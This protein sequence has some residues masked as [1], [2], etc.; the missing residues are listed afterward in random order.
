[1]KDTEDAGRP[2][3]HSSAELKGIHDELMNRYQAPEPAADIMLFGHG[4]YDPSRG[5]IRMPQGFQFYAPEEMALSTT[6]AVSMASHQSHGVPVKLQP[7]VEYLPN[8]QFGKIDQ[9][10]RLAVAMQASLSSSGREKLR[11]CGQDAEFPN[12][13]FM[14]GQDS[15]GC[16]SGDHSCSGLLGRF[17]GRTVAIICCRIDEVAFPTPAMVTDDF[18][19]GGEEAGYGPQ[20]D[21]SAYAIELLQWCRVNQP[22]SLYYDQG[23]FAEFFYKLTP[24]T[25]ALYLTINPIYRWTLVRALF[26]QADHMRD[27][28]GAL[29]H[30]A[31]VRTQNASDFAMLLDSTDVEAALTPDTY[32]AM[33]DAE[34]TLHPQ[35]MY[36]SS[37][38]A[39]LLGAARADMRAYVE[40]QPNVY[41]WR[42]LR[43]A[44]SL[45]NGFTSSEAL[46][47]YMSQNYMDGD[48][49]VLEILLS[50]DG[51]KDGLSTPDYFLG[52]MWFL[53]LE[54]NDED[55][56]VNFQH[57]AEAPE[58]REAVLADGA[59]YTKLVELKAIP[60]DDSDYSLSDSEDGSDSDY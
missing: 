33:A 25:Q 47:T 36:T 12:D 22:D 14:C 19:Y 32:E 5:K 51:P 16:A 34:I 23:D 7:Y 39:E 59:I 55:F 30:L 52:I 37:V 44:H 45:S 11:V 17:K 8:Y 56:L 15:E 38:L 13:V 46:R 29:S 6:T 58:V 27:P 42:V 9:H 54:G 50:S 21:G 48:R 49:D 35:D 28:A 24:A 53:I 1:M 20:D 31:T 10:D 2:S 26:L 60:S 41:K 18:I 57:T 3:G 4:S 40:N 43:Y